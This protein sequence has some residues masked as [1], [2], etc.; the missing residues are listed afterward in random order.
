MQSNHWK[1]G[2]RIV[3]RGTEYPVDVTLTI[4]GTPVHVGR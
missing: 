2:Q 1:V 3:Q 4:V